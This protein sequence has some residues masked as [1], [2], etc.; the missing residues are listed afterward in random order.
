MQGL[1]RG[2]SGLLSKQGCQGTEVS[3]A[4]SHHC[5]RDNET[6]ERKV[7]TVSENHR[8]T[9]GARE[10]KTPTFGFFCFHLSPHLPLSSSSKKPEARGA[11]G[12]LQGFSWAWED[13]VK[14]RCWRWAGCLR[15]GGWWGRAA[16][17]EQMKAAPDWSQLGRE[18]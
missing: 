14:N 1:Y 13:R 9:R 18:G 2:W 3:K 12:G 4:G 15:H 16:W 6:R 5:P 10:E 17:Q 7:P 8:R 11:Q